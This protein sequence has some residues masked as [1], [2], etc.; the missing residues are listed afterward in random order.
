MF[1]NNSISASEVGAIWQTYQEKTLI[2]RVLEY[3]IEKSDN[4]QARNILGGLWQELNFYVIEM[5]ELFSEQGMV[6]PIG[7][8]SEDINLTAPKLYDNG[9]DIMFIR[10]LKE[11]SMGLYTL[12]MNMAY[13]K[14]VM[15]IYEGLTTITQ[16]IYKLSTCYL[17]ERGNLALPPQV[18][19]PKKNEIIESKKYMECF[20]LTGDKRALNNLEIGILHHNLQ[21]NNVGLQLITGF[22]QCA[23][24][25]EAATYFLKGKKLAKKQIKM[26]EDILREGDVRFSSSS[27]GTV[28]TSNV[29]PFSDKL[30]MH[31]IYIL[32]GFGLVGAGTGAFFSLRNDLSMKS[33][34]LAKD[35]YFYAQEGIKIKI[36]NG[37]FEEPPQMEDRNQLIKDKS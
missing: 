32:N 24:S 20:K 33:I 22:A 35:V 7:F 34:L 25:K 29:S 2:M 12:N 19:L 13:N 30:M 3:F 23:Q 36:K 21:S 5:E 1:Q 16:K 11:V 10:V 4:L 15:Q 6:K 28:T 8:T 14:R 37:W 31:C 17:L 27:V 9:F 26:M 18:S